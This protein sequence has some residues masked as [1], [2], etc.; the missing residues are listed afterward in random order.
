MNRELLKYTDIEKPDFVPTGC[1]FRILFDA[2]MNMMRIVCKEQ[3]LMDCI[4]DAFS[5]ENESYFYVSMHGYDID[6]KIYNINQFGYFKPG[7]FFDILSYISVHFKNPNVLYMSEQCREYVKDY[8]LPLKKFVK[9]Y[10]KNTFEVLNI[11][12]DSG[13]NSLL[14]E[15]KRYNLRDYQIEGIKKAIFE[16]YGRGLVELPTSSGKSL[17]IANFIYTM[18]KKIL[19]GLKY[20]IFVPNTQLVTQFYKD[21]LDYGFK[22]DDITQL[23]TKTKGGVKYN[24][25]ASIIISNRQFLF[26]NKDKIPNVDVLI[27]DE[28]HQGKAKSA[29][30]EIVDGL[31]CKIKLGFSGTLPRGKYERLSLIGSFGRVLF[32][33]DITHLQKA[34]YISKLEINLIKIKDKS[35]END[36]KLTFNENSTRKFNIN[37]PDGP[38]FNEAFDDEIAYI[39]KNYEKLYAPIISELVN[40]EGNT[41]VLF[42]RLEFGKNMFDMAKGFSFGKGVHYIDGQTPVSERETAREVLEKS[43]NN[44]LFGQCS[45]LSTGI[46]I[47]NLTN[48]VMMVSTKSFSRV[49]QSIG[50]TL[51]LHKDKDTARLF[52]I[53]FNFKYSQKHL[54]E[55][56]QIYSSMYNKTPDTLRTIEV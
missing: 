56:L 12:D 43:N 48:L 20:L 29:T 16:G 24:P 41:L 25:D 32:V 44:I 8:L 28:V 10:D 49:I 15:D 46:N 23:V 7:L 27:N 37:N 30:L 13:R 55:R 2:N 54:S 42:D 39:N 5:A 14:P 53:S 19:H 21:L 9:K 51:R 1:I 52:D 17:V 38:R 40:L 6:R 4:R 47:K 33:E 31:N 35:V 26:K 34:G 36:R 18:E 3:M 45:I 22:K 50:R 11:C